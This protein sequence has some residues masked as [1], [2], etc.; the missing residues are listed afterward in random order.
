[1]LF[2][3]LFADFFSN[4]FKTLLFTRIKF[5]LRIF[6]LVFQN[7]HEISFHYVDFGYFS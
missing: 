7:Q 5:E 4:N 2:F 1:M 6:N 3:V